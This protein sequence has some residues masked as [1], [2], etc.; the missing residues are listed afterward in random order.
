MYSLLNMKKRLF[1]TSL[2]LCLAHI[3]LLIGGDDNEKYWGGCSNLLRTIYSL[4]LRL[5]SMKHVVVIFIGVVQLAFQ[6]SIL[7]W[8]LLHKSSSRIF[9][10]LDLEFWIFYVAA[11][12]EALAPCPLRSLPFHFEETYCGSC[13]TSLM[14]FLPK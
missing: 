8:V 5:W 4:Q 6:I 9:R 7:K 3:P 12:V 10:C 2:F 13:K 11:Q 14:E 1:L